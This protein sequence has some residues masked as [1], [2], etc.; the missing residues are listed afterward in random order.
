MSCLKDFDVSAV[1]IKSTCRS[2]YFKTY[3]SDLYF[4]QRKVTNIILKTI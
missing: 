1:K 3:L 2:T 4:D